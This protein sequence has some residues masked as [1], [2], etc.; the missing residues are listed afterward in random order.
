MQ[1][2][3]RDQVREIDRR[4]T[5]QFGLPSLVLMENAGRSCVEV[6]VQHGCRGPVVICCGRGNNGGDG[7][8]I[9]R[10]LDARG[11]RVKILLFASPVELRGDAAVNY[12]I[13]LLS[14]L[15]IVAFGKDAQADAIAKE[16]QATEWIVDALLGTGATGNP[17]PPIAT[18]IHCLNAATAKCFAVDLPSG[19]DSD[20][21]EPGDPTVRADVT[22]SFV[23]PKAGF[24][25]PL[26]RPFL[27][28]VEVGSIGAPRVLLEEYL[29]TDQQ[30]A[31]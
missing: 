17:K 19:L 3:R 4:C 7:F 14:R 21:G 27:G 5:E 1:S 25:N 11:I 2:L 18:A 22:V 31:Q 23:A 6:L 8:V 13:A 16:L 29:R 26:A 15:P 30:V 9:A 28:V 12:Q 10:L 24:A 20:T